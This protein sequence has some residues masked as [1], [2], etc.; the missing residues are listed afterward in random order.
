[1]KQCSQAS[2]TARAAALSEGHAGFMATDSSARLRMQRAPAP[3]TARKTLPR[4]IWLG[5]GLGLR[6]GLGLGLGPGSGLGLGL[7]LGPGFTA[8]TSR[9]HV[10]SPDKEAARIS[11]H[12]CASRD[13]GGDGGGDGG[14]W[15]WRWREMA[16]EMAR[17][18]G[19][20]REMVGGGGRSRWRWR[21]MA[22]YGAV[23]DAAGRG[24]VQQLPWAGVCVGRGG[25]GGGCLVGQVAPVEVGASIVVRMH[26][27]PRGRVGQ[28][29][30][31][32]LRASRSA[33]GSGAEGRQST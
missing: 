4:L 26:L 10:Q 12:A 9:P 14:R 32:A 31:V 17:D 24:G 20:W 30:G 27:R 29:W 3:D 18:G 15:R 25:R 7:G 23:V 19:R 21:E 22:G 28:R 11:V 2:W 13:G 16:V 6:L 8:R 5:L 1:M 33:V